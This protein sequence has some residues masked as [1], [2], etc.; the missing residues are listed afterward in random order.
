MEGFMLLWDFAPL[1]KTKLIYLAMIGQMLIAIY[2]YTAMSRARVS[3]G[4]A[5]R[6]K[7]DDYK[8]THNEPEDLRVLT[9]A[10]ANQFE[11]PVIFY[12]LML[13]V[14]TAATQSWITVVLAWLFV[15]LRFVHARE[16]ISSNRVLLRRKI[17]IQSARVLLLMV[18]EFTLVML[19]A[20]A[21]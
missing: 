14:L 13:A 9:R 3:A 17:F 10:V 20:T 6:I 21:L 18:V 19:F 11:M 4:K 16:M 1:L 5:K 15:I 8:A 2:C 12:A 7:P